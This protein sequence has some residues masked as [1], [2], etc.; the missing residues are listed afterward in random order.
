MP[1]AAHDAIRRQPRFP[2]AVWNV[3]LLV[4]AHGDPVALWIAQDRP[5]RTAGTEVFL[6]KAKTPYTLTF[7]GNELNTCLAGL[8]P[9]TDVVWRIRGPR[10]I[11]IVAAYA[12]LHIWKFL[13]E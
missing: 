1:E 4:R 6:A 3:T 12:A 9:P 7:F 5:S 10:G 11:E 13:A 8:M 2:A